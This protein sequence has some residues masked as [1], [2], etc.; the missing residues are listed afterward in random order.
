MFLEIVYVKDVT[1][2]TAVEHLLIQM[3]CSTGLCR[4]KFEESDPPFLNYLCAK[5]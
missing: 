3:S 2:N 1:L 4:H 5:W